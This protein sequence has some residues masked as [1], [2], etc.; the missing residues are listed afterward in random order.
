MLH[1]HEGQTLEPLEVCPIINF[2][3][4][5]LVEV[6]ASWPWTSGYIKTHISCALPNILEQR[7]Q[8]D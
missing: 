1:S 7:L 6:G 8:E 5:N 2:R 3:A 4:L